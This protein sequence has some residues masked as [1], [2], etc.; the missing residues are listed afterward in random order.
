MGT[1]RR[2]T[3]GRYPYRWSFHGRWWWIL[4]RVRWIPISWIIPRFCTSSGNFRYVWQIVRR[5]NAGA[6]AKYRKNYVPRKHK[7]YNTST[8]RFYPYPRHRRNIYRM[9]TTWRMS[10][11]FWRIVRFSRITSLRNFSCE[12]CFWGGRTR[13]WH[14]SFRRWWITLGVRWLRNRWCNFLSQPYRSQ[15][16]PKSDSWSDTTI[17]RLSVSRM[18]ETCDGRVTFATF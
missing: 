13:Y 4:A 2:C 11:A 3:N 10:Y 6:S 8:P 5:K 15:S 16:I 18:F 1:R 14:W 7:V 9:D 12:T 17:S